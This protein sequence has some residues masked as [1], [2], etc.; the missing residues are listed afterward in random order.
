M[1]GT[2]GMSQHAQRCCLLHPARRRRERCNVSRR[3]AAQCWERPAGETEPFHL[4]YLVRHRVQKGAKR[5]GHAQLQGGRTRGHGRCPLTALRA[6]L[7]FCPC[8]SPSVAPV[9]IHRPWHGS[10]ADRRL[11]TAPATLITHSPSPT[12]AKRTLRARNPSS[13][14]VSAASTNTSAVEML[15]YW[16]VVN[17]RAAAPAQACWPQRCSGLCARV[18]MEACTG[19][20]AVAQD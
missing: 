15:A 1:Q 3:H 20:V 13:Q 14:S 4:H 18:Q 10:E 9:L 17:L 8:C 2:A 16:C 19:C 11:A 12:C 6:P 7:P 5:G